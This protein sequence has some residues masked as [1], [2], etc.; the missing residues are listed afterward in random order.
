MTETRYLDLDLLMRTARRTLGVVEV[1]D[2]GL[3]ESAAARP[4]TSVFG[5]DAYPTLELKAAALAHSVIR[6]HALVDGNTRLALA[7]VI[8]FVGLN[9]MVLDLTNDEAYDLFYAIAAGDLDDLAARLRL[10]PR[11]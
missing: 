3:L 5:Q 6:N 7:S 2:I 1:R 9:G 8:A 11:T 4:R 10:A